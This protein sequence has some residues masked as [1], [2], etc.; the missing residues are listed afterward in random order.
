MSPSQTLAKEAS[1]EDLKRWIIIPIL[2]MTTLW[3]GIAPAQPLPGEESQR[4]NE[5][6]R[7]RQIERDRARQEAQAPTYRHD[8]HE[9]ETYVAG[10]GGYSWG[11]K[12]HDVEGTGAL[13]G[14]TFGDRD[15]K[16]SGVY[17]GKIGYFLPDRWR[18]LG[19]EAEAFHTTPHL[20]QSGLAEGT[21]LGVTTAALNVV[22]RGLLG[23]R[24]ADRD[25]RASRTADGYDRDGE[26]CPLQPYAGLGI[27]VFFARASDIDGRSSDHA[28]PGLNA[29]AGLRYFVTEHVAVFGEYK[30]NYAT[31]KFNDIEGAGAGLRGD[32]SVSHAVG[33]LS[34]HF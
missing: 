23:C 30:Y 9:G 8:R 33:G 3:P 20:K 32:Y 7:A 17:G 22:A 10:F 4:A 18:W 21:H 16:N 13:S 26:F 31:F 29:L 34:F 6:E 28:A 11:H 19:F 24:R 1:V 14:T 2:S 15:L 27:G 25:V 12:F 5:M